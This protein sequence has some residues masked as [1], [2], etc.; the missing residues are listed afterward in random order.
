MTYVRTT[1]VDDSAPA[2]NATN[3]NKIEQG[4]FDAHAKFGAL[5]DADVAAGAAIAA[6]KI[7][8]PSASCDIQ[9]STSV[10]DASTTI[11]PLSASFRWN[12]GGFTNTYGIDVPVAGLYYAECNAWWDSNSTG[13][14]FFEIVRRNS[15]GAEQE[16]RS[17]R[18]AAQ[19]DSNQLFGY[20]F[21]PCAAGDQFFARCFQNSGST[22]NLLGATLTV[23]RVA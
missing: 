11:C 14:R 19:A 16:I 2:V 10:P 8:I 15:S 1:W 18:Y 12:Y 7:L 23:T 13:Y 4:I 22:I 9:G 17:H 5:A 21:G 3:L 6:S 20:T